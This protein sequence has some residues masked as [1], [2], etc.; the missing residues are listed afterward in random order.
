MTVVTVAAMFA[1]RRLYYSDCSRSFSH[2]GICDM[3][4][5]TC[6]TVTFGAPHR[7]VT[8]LAVDVREQRVYWSDPEGTVISSADVTGKDIVAIK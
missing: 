4:V 1:C 8:S 2:I 3:A 5:E 7:C 6:S